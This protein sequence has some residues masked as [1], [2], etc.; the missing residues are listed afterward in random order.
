MTH[1]ILQL[2]DLPRGRGDV[3]LKG[4]EQVLRN[5]LL[6]GEPCAGIALV[7][8][9]RGIDGEM[10]DADEFLNTA[11]NLAAEALSENRLSSQA[12]RRAAARD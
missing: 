2:H 10:R 12:G 8:A 5:P 6:Q 4:K 7:S 1:L 9:E 11:A 3:R